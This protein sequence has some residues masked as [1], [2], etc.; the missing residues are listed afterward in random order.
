MSDIKLNKEFLE[1]NGYVLVKNVLTP[2]EVEF[3][4]K[5]AYDLIAE[6]EKKGTYFMHRYA[7]NHIG[8]LTTNEKTRKLILNDKVISLA[9]QILGK[10]PLYFGDA[11]MEIG[12]GSR[13]WHKD[14][15]YTTDPNHE[16]WVNKDYPVYRFAIY[17]QDHKNHS[18]GLKIK[19][20]T[21]NILSTKKGNPVILETE[22]G[23]IAIFNLRA[24]H[25]GNAVR[26]KAMPKK[27]WHNSIEKRIPEFLKVP[28]EKERVSYFLTY[29]LKS[30]QLDRYLNFM[31]NHDKYK[32]RI[33]HFEYTP[34]VVKEIE[35]KLDF[36][37][38]KE[39]L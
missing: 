27:S 33:S 36:L 15:S 2:E 17:L 28:E 16:D 10:K 1:E 35:E 39:R 8:C 14:V 26:L 32:K 29:G 38:L 20:K 6:D 37:N 23:D 4:R 9:T 31:L 5:A 34:E 18:G 13:G 12:I 24:T 25:A 21:Q 3:F 30:P 22:P 7:K 19:E 11:I